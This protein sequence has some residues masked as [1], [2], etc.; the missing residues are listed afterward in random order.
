[1][2]IN[3]SDLIHVLS[4]SR[5][6]AHAVRGYGRI[7]GAVQARAIT[8][9]RPVPAGHPVRNPHANSRA[10]RSHRAFARSIG[11]SRTT[12]GAP[13]TTHRHRI[14]D[15]RR[16]SRE[17]PA[18][19]AGSSVL[20]DCIAGAHRTVHRAIEQATDTHRAEQQCL[21][22]EARRLSGRS[23]LG[24]LTPILRTTVARRTTIG[25]Y[26]AKHRRLSHKRR[27][28]SHGRQLP[29]SLCNAVDH[30]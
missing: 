12:T 22:H 25:K 30:H 10:R 2:R 29:K 8:G 20:I 21:S 5:F 26:H 7:A 14:H 6:H 11:I 13:H 4:G 17:A 9:T 3:A 24:R 15:D 23:L 27:R 19:I 18:R 28:P 16:I 1:M